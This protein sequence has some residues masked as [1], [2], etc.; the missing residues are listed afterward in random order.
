M[1]I[2]TEENETIVRRVCD[3]VAADA[4]AKVKITPERQHIYDVDYLVM[5]TNSGV[6][7]EQYFRWASV[8][9]I[10]R[11]VHALRTVGIED[12]ADLAERAIEIA[13]PCGIPADDETKSDLTDWS[14][15][16]ERSLESLFPALEE[17][18]GRI[19]NTLAAYAVRVGA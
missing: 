6:S 4:E 15:E 5:E 19:I 12:I 3:S 10:S 2:S 9:E 16:Q 11:V 18:N 7:F 13:F 8:D 1:E 17:Q 14:E